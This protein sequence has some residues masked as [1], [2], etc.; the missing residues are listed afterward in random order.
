MCWVA[1]GRQ[2]VSPE[3]RIK[4]IWQRIQTLYKQYNVPSRLNNLI[5]AMFVQESQPHASHPM[6]KCKGAETKYL[7][8]I[9]AQISQETSTSSE[10]DRHRTHLLQSLSRFGDLLDTMPMFPAEAEA[11]DAQMAMAAVLE[12]ADWLKQKAVVD[13]SELWHIVYKHHF[14]EHLAEACKWMNPRFGWT[15]R[16]EDYV[17]K[18]SLLPHSCCFGVRPMDLSG[19]ILEKWRIMLHVKMS[20][21]IDED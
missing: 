6:L 2:T 8:P 15:F 12:H 16:G 1:R 5:L 18:V 4:A 21:H 19:K 14:A 17:G 10:E 11:H 9:V 20:R 7:L 3:E 13:G